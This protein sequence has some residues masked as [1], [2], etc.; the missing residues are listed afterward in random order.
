MKASV[1]SA[2]EGS[3]SRLK[4]PWRLLDLKNKYLSK[5]EADARLF[6]TLWLRVKQVTHQN[7]SFWPCQIC[8]CTKQVMIGGLRLMICNWFSRALS[9]H[10]V[11]FEGSWE[12]KRALLNWYQ[13]AEMENLCGQG[14]RKSV[15][16]V[17]CRGN[18]KTLL[19]KI[20]Y[21]KFYGDKDRLQRMKKGLSV[22][23]V[24]EA[25]LEGS[26]ISYCKLWL[27]WRCVK[28]DC[29]LGDMLFEDNVHWNVK[30]SI[31]GWGGVDLEQIYAEK[32]VGTMICRALMLCFPRPLLLPF[33]VKPRQKPARI[34]HKLVLAIFVQYEEFGGEV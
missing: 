27:V 18:G 4:V 15:Q 9:S 8:W 19:Y 12:R 11:N 13:N 29:K 22:I 14:S 2:L 1:G 32:I 26:W 21:W 10:S 30:K 23:R 3:E 28:K 20:L 34:G 24:L 6:M 17:I 7:Q 31:G 16:F 33:G 5:M 25:G